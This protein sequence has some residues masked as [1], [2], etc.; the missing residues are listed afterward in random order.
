MAAASKKGAL[1]S[2]TRYMVPQFN[3]TWTCWLLNHKRIC[4]LHGISIQMFSSDKVNFEGRNSSSRA[5]Q[6]HTLQCSPKFEGLTH[7]AKLP[8]PM[9]LLFVVVVVVV[10]FLYLPF[11]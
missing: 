3:L 11:P 2:T 1:M 8:M 7:V 9:P 5:S 10:V 4:F 6:K